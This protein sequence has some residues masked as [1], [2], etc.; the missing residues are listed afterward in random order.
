MSLK[1]SYE[2][3]D[4]GSIV[5]LD[6]H[7]QPL[8]AFVESEVGIWSNSADDPTFSATVKNLGLNVRELEVVVPAEL[9]G[10]K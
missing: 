3:I 4:V 9:A 8:A 1:D 5:V 7:G 6:A 2:V 10:R